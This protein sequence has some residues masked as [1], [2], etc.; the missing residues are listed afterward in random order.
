MNTASENRA[1]SASLPKT[2][3]NEYA[4]LLATYN[5]PGKN[6]CSC[7]LCSRYVAVRKVRNRCTMQEMRKGVWESLM[8]RCVL[9]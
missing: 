5:R 9:Q 6:I 4:L 3:A 1:R 8:S 7:S 2:H